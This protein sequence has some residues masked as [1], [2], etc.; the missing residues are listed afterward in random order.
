MS[1]RFELRC[2]GEAYAEKRDLLEAMALTIAHVRTC[3]K[4][5]MAWVD[6]IDWYVV[7]SGA[8]IVTAAGGQWL[9]HHIV[10]NTAKRG[11]P[12]SG[13]NS[14]YGKDPLPTSPYRLVWTPR[15]GQRRNSDALTEAVDG[16]HEM[17]QAII[18]TL[19][20]DKDRN[21]WQSVAIDWPQPERFK[22]LE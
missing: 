3:P 13:T 17:L 9:D 8:A 7:D 5:A 22:N 14:R 21:Y 10:E 16:Q 4:G 12:K 15:E 19:Q 1:T 18:D 2:Y 20:I 11:M 6:T